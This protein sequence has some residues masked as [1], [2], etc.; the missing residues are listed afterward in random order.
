MCMKLRLSFLAAVFFIPYSLFAQ[1]NKTSVDWKK[2]LPQSKIDQ[3]VLFNTNGQNDKKLNQQIYSSFIYNEN[4]GDSLTK[5]LPQYYENK[6]VITDP[7]IIAEIVTAMPNDT[8]SAPP[9]NRCHPQYRD[10]L[11]FYNKN[12]LVFTLKVCMEC[13]S[14][15]SMP[16]KPASKCLANNMQNVMIYILGIDMFGDRRW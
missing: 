7:S 4:H 6:R 2:F 12:K 11:L 16:S 9:V 5:L 3:I 10:I 8:C 13:G 1:E 14:T 15:V